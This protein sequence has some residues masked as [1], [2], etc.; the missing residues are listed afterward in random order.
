MNSFVDRACGGY[1][2]TIVDD[3]KYSQCIDAVKNAA[4]LLQVRLII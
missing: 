1:E 4:R 2:I 3:E